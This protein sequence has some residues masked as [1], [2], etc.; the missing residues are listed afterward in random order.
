LG[1]NEKED[2]ENSDNIDIDINIVHEQVKSMQ[3][4]LSEFCFNRKIN[5]SSN[6]DYSNSCY[7][8]NPPIIQLKDDEIY[9]L[10]DLNDLQSDK[11]VVQVLRN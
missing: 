10:S 4:E 7:E 1:E 11:R 2:E 9:N 5:I 8:D 3:S 6:N